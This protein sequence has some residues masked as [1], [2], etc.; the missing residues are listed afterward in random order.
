MIQPGIKLDQAVP[1]RLVVGGPGFV[2]Q[3]RRSITCWACRENLRTEI[4]H[5]CVSSWR[6]VWGPRLVCACGLRAYRDDLKGR[7]VWLGASQ[8][9]ERV[10]AMTAHGHAAAHTTPTRAAGVSSPPSFGRRNRRCV[11]LAAGARR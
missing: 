2:V 10:N 1:G 6:G 11:Q 3:L 4:A 9:D 8:G 5:T 7:W